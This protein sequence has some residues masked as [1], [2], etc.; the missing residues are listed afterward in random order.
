MGWKTSMRI[1]DCLFV[2]LSCSRSADHLPPIF[3]RSLV[4][5]RCTDEVYDTA[6]RLSVFT[7][8]LALTCQG[9]AGGALADVA[10][11]A[12]CNYRKRWKFDF[13]PLTG[14]CFWRCN[15][16]IMEVETRSLKECKIYEISIVGGFLWENIKI[17]LKIRLVLFYAYARACV[18]FCIL[19]PYRTF[20]LLN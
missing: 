8:H 6:R 17:V 15:E 2:F 5:A 9:V 20:I 19:I 12:C 11:R 18:H 13:R 3:S 7:L 4:S 14:D 1:L 16:G 10:P